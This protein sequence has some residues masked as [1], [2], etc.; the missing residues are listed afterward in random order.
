MRFMA[1]HGVL[2][3]A[4]RDLVL[5]MAPRSRWFRARVNSGSLAEPARYEPGGSADARLPRRGSPAPDVTLP[6]GTRLRDCVGEDYIVVTPSFLS[7][8]DL[9]V[10]VVPVGQGTVYGDEAWLV[11]PDGYIADSRSASRAGSFRVG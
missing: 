9:R 11:R 1:P 3:R 7:D 2:R 4:W 8:T 5:R 6:D 10:R